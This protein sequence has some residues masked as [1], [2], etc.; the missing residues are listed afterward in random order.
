MIPALSEKLDRTFRRWRHR[1][2]ETRFGLE[3]GAKA[4]R[5]ARLRPVDG[6]WRLDAGAEAPL[7]EGALPMNFRQSEALDEEALGSAL[8][9]VAGQLG[10]ARRRVAVALPDAL[11]KLQMERF[12]ALPEEPAEARRLAAWQAARR[13]GVSAADLSVDLFP[14]GLN[15]E[16]E[17]EA[18]V[19]SALRPVI[20]KYEAAIRNAGMD[21]EPILPAAVAR[22]NLHAGELPDEGTAILLIFTDGYFHLL[23]VELGRWM[24]LH[25]IRG[26]LDG[27]RLGRDLFLVAEQLRD[28]LG[29]QKI[30]AVYLAD[31]GAPLWNLAPALDG[32]FPAPLSI[33]RPDRRLAE[34]SLDEEGGP[35][36]ASLGTAIGAAAG[37]EIGA[38]KKGAAK[39]EE[40]A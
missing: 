33:L 26:G 12:P 27:E 20:R 29:D 25:S 34:V 32:L 5:G 6:G 28:D 30:D 37:L 18:V 4:V 14:L 31:P 2:R 23:L 1:L 13:F 17:P 36:A 11:I 15:A 38:E 22:F 35:D 16:G 19:A 39:K 9:S 40:A 3:I 8:S 24:G 21:P 10:A 7:P